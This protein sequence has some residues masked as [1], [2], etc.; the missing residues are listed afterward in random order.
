[1]C[2][3][4]RPRPINLR[5][6]EPV[7]IALGGVRVFDGSGDRVDVGA[8]RHPDGQSDQVAVSLP[9]LD[10]GTYVVTWRVTSA[11]AHPVEGAFTFQ[12]GPEA[13]VDDAAGSSR[14]CSPSRVAARAV[15][16][17]YAIDRGLVFAS[18][19]VFI[20]GVVFVTAILRPG[21]RSP[22]VGPS[23]ERRAGRIVRIGWIT[24]LGATLVG[25]ALEGVYAAALPLSKVFDPSVWSDV[26]DT[27]YGKVALVRVALLLV[28]LPLARIA[29][30]AEREVPR[31]WPVPAGLVA[32]AL[33]ATPGIAGHA[34]TGDHVGLAVV[35]DT[36]HVLAM[37]CW[38]GGLVMLLAI[39][40]VRPLPEG[41]RPTVNRFSAL[42]LGCVAVLVVTGGF[43]AWRQV[44]SLEA[45]RDTDFGRLLL[46]KL[47]VFAALVVA[48]AFSREVVNRR[49]RDPIDAAAGHA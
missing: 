32:V 34:S 4:S 14:A 8:P 27:R 45:L 16:V 36:L 22:P 31:W 7:E 47:I 43:Q 19:A 21:R 5:F 49:F 41:L 15:G 25:I 3:T 12:V 42:A 24:A 46:V 10:D 11:D 17:L 13:T 38:L 40:L 18:L 26:L 33:A 6:T 37:S 1:M 28:A 20:G 2:T 30:R 9:A 23:P 39:V 29:L 35:S 48:A 44:G